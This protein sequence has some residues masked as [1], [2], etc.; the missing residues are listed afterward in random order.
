MSGGLA[1]S[2]GQKE[3][4]DNEK[5]QTHPGAQVVVVLEDNGWRS[6]SMVNALATIL[7]QEMLGYRVVFHHDTHTQVRLSTCPET[8]SEYLS[9]ACLVGLRASACAQHRVRAIFA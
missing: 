6:Q 3:N 4:G 5:V 1:L 9:S 2:F 8:P 7:L